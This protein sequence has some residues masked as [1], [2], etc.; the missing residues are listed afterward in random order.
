MKI[1]AITCDILSTARQQGATQ[2]EDTA[3]L[4]FPQVAPQSTQIFPGRA[5]TRHLCVYP[6][7]RSPARIR[8]RTD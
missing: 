2:Y 7:G 5:D 1:T 6:S 4:K 8:V 3:G